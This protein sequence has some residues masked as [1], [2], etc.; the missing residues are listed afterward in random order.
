MTGR[1]LCRHIYCRPVQPT[2]TG[3]TTSRPRAAWRSVTNA[4]CHLADYSQITAAAAAAAT[5]HYCERND[6]V[7]S[8]RGF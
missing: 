3:R 8:L 2:S 4:D 5:W 6:S 1:G 7:A